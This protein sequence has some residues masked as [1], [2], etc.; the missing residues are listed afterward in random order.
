VVVCERRVSRGQVC[1]RGLHE[2]K[3][4]RDFGL[5]PL[6]HAGYLTSISSSMYSFKSPS[7]RGNQMWS[8]QDSDASDGPPT[9]SELFI[10]YQTTPIVI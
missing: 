8:K 3:K 6:L 9:L 10:M 4:S 7:V 2:V 5:D 1:D